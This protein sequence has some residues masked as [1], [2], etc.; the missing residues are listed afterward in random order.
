MAQAV[1]LLPNKHKALSSNP[2][3]S[4]AMQGCLIPGKKKKKEMGALSA[5][6][7]GH[8]EAREGE[9]PLGF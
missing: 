9:E 1:G 6:G 8:E 2:F 3:T 4:L 7:S 5:T